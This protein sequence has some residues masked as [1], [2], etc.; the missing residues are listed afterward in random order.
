MWTLDTEEHT[1]DMQRSWAEIPPAFN[2]MSICR[3][4]RAPDPCKD[5]R[6]RLPALT[7]AESGLSELWGLSCD[8]KV[9]SV[10]NNSVPSRC[11]CESSPPSLQVLCQPLGMAEPNLVGLRKGSGRLSLHTGLCTGRAGVSASGSCTTETTQ[12]LGCEKEVM[13]EVRGI[14]GKHGTQEEAG[15]KKLDPQ[16][17]PIDSL[18]RCHCE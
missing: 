2:C 14:L 3:G 18:H 10:Q 7:P 15:S 11:P 1:Q 9:A 5:I 6:N 4:V 17:L 13:R 16:I 12:G 8:T